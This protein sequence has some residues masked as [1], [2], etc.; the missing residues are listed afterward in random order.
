MAWVG[1]AFAAQAAPPTFNHDIAPIIFTHCVG[2]HHPGALGPFSLTT[3]HDVSK[4]AKLIA[5]VTGAHYM[6]PWLPE[7]GHGD[8]LGER[9]LTTEQ[10]T[11]I[12][13]WYQAGA[14]EG[15]AAD[16]QAK[17]EWDDDWRLGPPDLVLNMPRTYHL[18]AEG[19][20][21]YRNFVLPNVTAQ[22]RWVRAVE[23]RPGNAR[24]VHHASVLLS[25]TSDALAREGLEAEPGFP[26]M[27]PGRGVGRPAGHIVAWQPGKQVLE[28]PAGSAWLLP[29]GANLVLQLHMRPDGKT[30]P[31]EVSIGLYFTDHP[32]AR[33]T[34]ALMIRSTAIDI[35]AGAKDYPVEASY[36]LP[37]DVDVMAV[38][39]HLHYLGKE[40][41]GWAALPDG[42]ER[43]LIYIPR[44]DFNWQGDYR[45]ARPLHLPARTTVHMRYIYDNSSHNPR[46][47]HQPPQEVFFGPQSSDEMGELTLQLLPRNGAEKE[48]LQQDYLI[49]WLQDDDISCARAYLR[50]DPKDAKSR[51]DLGLALQATGQ[52]S[53]AI[54]ELSQAL[55]DDPTL[56]RAHYALGVIYAGRNLAREAREELARAVALDPR[57][58]YGWI[59]LASGQ[60]GAAIEQL[61]QAVRLN[62]KDVL[63]REN[64][65]KAL[66]M[67]Q[68][69]ASRR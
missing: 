35:P 64:L 14:P 20:D 24:V 59:L 32:A 1:S 55:E 7:A 52:V 6:P 18:P 30:E 46:N 63:A 62:P 2:C 22:D 33:D 11:L 45:Y 19:Q 40:A 29:Q 60:T 37:V 47:P 31:V 58:N 49:H 68:R 15:N 43:E 27:D 51:V 48:L 36:T 50:R 10:I 38:W 53:A 57:N 5:Q 34:V 13:Q 54:K 17:A 12:E 4:R 67:R 28:E 65:Q 3:F 41:H 69:E 23:I 26:G 9:R 61:Q 21:V 66:A 44:W 56:A 25:Q 42:T 8:F 39:P 16:L